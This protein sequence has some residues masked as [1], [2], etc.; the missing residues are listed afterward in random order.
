MPLPGEACVGQGRHIEGRSE[1][2]KNALCLGM[3]PDLF[4][5]SVSAE[6]PAAK[7]ICA[8][9]PVQ[10]ECLEYAL[11]NRIAHGIWGGST[12]R[13]RRLMIRKRN[14]LSRRATIY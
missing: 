9:C 6:I 12:E 14:G 13:Q 5:P 11:E 10:S 3:D 4:F 2:R 7:A 8:D 1:W